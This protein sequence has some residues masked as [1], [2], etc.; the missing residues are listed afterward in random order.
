M[1]LVHVQSVMLVMSAHSE[2]MHRPYALEVFMRLRDQKLAHH[3]KQVNIVQQ[4]LE[5]KHHVHREVIVIQLKQVVKLALL[6]ISVLKQLLFQYIVQLVNTAIKVL[7]NV[8]LVQKAIVAL[9]IMKIRNNVQVE[10]TV[11]QVKIIALFVHLVIIVL[12]VHQHQLFVKVVHIVMK[13]QVLKFSVLQVMFVLKVR[14]I[15]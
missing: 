4:D 1:E 13:E 11:H 7:M 12:L 10:L 6:V 5:F 2:Q 15:L 8:L 9:F 14:T 3:V